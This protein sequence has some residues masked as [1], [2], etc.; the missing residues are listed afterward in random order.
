EA[1]R[2]NLPLFER[3]AGTEVEDTRRRDGIA[4]STEEALCLVQVC[5]GGL[6]VARPPL[7]APQRERAGSREEGAALAREEL[8]AALGDRDC[9]GW[10]VA[11]DVHVG[12]IV[13]GEPAGKVALSQ[14][15]TER[16]GLLIVGQRLL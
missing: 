11:D 3:E 1:P 13:P 8:V 2:L 7:G 16:E 4:E 5:M 6:H 15:A 12:D 14:L 9:P 10:L